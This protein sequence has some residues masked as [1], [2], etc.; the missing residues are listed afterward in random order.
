MFLWL[1]V[2]FFIAIELS[3]GEGDFQNETINRYVLLGELLGQ[4]RLLEYRVQTGSREVLRSYNECC[5]SR[6]PARQFKN[7]DRDCIR[8]I[9][10]K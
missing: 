10:R 3:S 5:Q 7:L 4:D 1:S 8:R 6:D 2:K 9:F